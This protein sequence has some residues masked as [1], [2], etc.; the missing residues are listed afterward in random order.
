MNCVNWGKSILPLFPSLTTFCREEQDTACCV[1][2]RVKGGYRCDFTAH[3]PSCSWCGVH[4]V[5]SPS[6]CPAQAAGDA[7]LRA[8]ANNVER[9]RRGPC[10]TCTFTKRRA[11]SYKTPASPCADCGLPTP[12]IGHEA[13]LNSA[14]EVETGVG[15]GVT[16]KTA[17]P[18]GKVRLRGN[19]ATV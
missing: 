9:S 16:E 7:G 12:R 19:A 13:T 1:A 18:A 4:A 17:I 15:G 8:R 2:M 6:P 14:P 3:C 5:M 10:T 11:L